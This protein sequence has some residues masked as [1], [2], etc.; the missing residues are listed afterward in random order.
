MVGEVAVGWGVTEDGVA[1]L[2]AMAVDVARGMMVAVLEA[3]LD[4]KRC[5]QHIQRAD[6]APDLL[7]MWKCVRLRLASTGNGC[8]LSST[9][10][11]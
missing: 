10:C 6:L 7:V 4:G 3:P 5:T 2:V 8:G 9:C 11:H 1:G